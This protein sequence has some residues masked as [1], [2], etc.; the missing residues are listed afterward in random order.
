[1]TF[2]KSLCFDDHAH[3]C[4]NA[5]VSAGLGLGHRVYLVRFREAITCIRQQRILV[6]LERDA[7][8]TAFSMMALTIPLLQC[9]AHSDKLALQI[10]QP[11]HLECGIDLIAVLGRH[12][13]KR[14]AQASSVGR[15]SVSFSL[16]SR[17]RPSV[18]CRRSR[19]R[20]P[21]LAPLSLR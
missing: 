1:M 14:E 9:S 4:L 10:D 8:V 17:K 12:R 18:I 19:L 2:G 20:H 16:L 21:S 7:E 13:R 15:F 6:A 5:T 11:N 3:A